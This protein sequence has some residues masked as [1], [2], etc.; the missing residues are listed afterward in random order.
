MWILPCPDP[1]DPGLEL[2]SITPGLKGRS[3]V[4]VSIQGTGL[5]RVDRGSAVLSPL[6][7]ERSELESDTLDYQRYGLV[8]I[9][10]FATQRP[11]IR[12]AL[13]ADASEI[14][15]FVRSGGVVMTLAQAARDLNGA[16]VPSGPVNWAINHS[17]RSFV[18]G[19]SFIVPSGNRVMQVS[20]LSSFFSVPDTLLVPVRLSP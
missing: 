10:S 18:N 14:A 15:T 5:V 19:T 13:D 17:I 8:L 12:L 4:A 11:S 9:D 1:N 3:P 6:M 16:E 7:P 20:C 2:I